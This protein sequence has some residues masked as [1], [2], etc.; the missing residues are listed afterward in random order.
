MHAKHAKRPKI[1]ISSRRRHTRLT[2]DW[3]SDVCSSDLTIAETGHLVFATLHTNDT[4]Q[5]IDRIVDLFPGDRRNQIQ[6]QLAHV[7]A[8]VVYQRLLPRN[9]GGLVAAFEVMVGN[10]A[11]RNLVREGKTS[12]LRNVVATHQNDGMRTLEMDLPRL[13]AEGVIDLQ[14]AREISL[15]PREVTAPPEPEPEPAP[16]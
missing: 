3:S 15:H 10:H 14:A 1:F 12:Q 9:G 4:A 5:A 16:R 11:V 8:G 7:L 2:C 6:V 13:V